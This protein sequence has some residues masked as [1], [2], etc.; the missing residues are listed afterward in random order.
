MH[1]VVVHDL[2]C[3]D[4]PQGRTYRQINAEKTHEIPI[5]ALVETENGVRAFVVLQGRDCD[6]TPLYYL[7]MKQEDVG[8]TAVECGAW[9][10][11]MKAPHWY[12]GCSNV[13]LVRLPEDQL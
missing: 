3:P 7:S 10:E 2:V 8:R 5:G 13:S 1:I 11:R 6:M 4:D 12:G 9:S